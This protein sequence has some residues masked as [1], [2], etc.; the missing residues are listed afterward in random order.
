MKPLPQRLLFITALL[1]ALLAGFGLSQWLSHGHETDGHAHEQDDHSR[2]K[3]DH[4]TANAHDEDEHGQASEEEH[5]EDRIA[6]T[7]RQIERAGIRVTGIG[8]GG[9]REIRLVG[10]VEPALAARASITSGVTARVEQWQVEPGA[11][12]KAGQVLVT[13][14]SSE[15]ANLHA[16]AQA[17]DADAE[18]ARLAYRR[19]HNLFEHGVIARQ[20][21]EASQARS[22]AA[23]AAANAARANAHLAGSP[24]AQGRLQLRSPLDGRIGNL[25]A[26]PGSTVAAGSTLT[27][28]HDPQRSELHFTVTPDVVAQLGTDSRLRVT[29]PGGEFDASVLGTS[30]SVSESGNQGLLRARAE[31]GTPLALGVPLSAT[32][33]I[34]NQ[35]ELRVPSE[36]VQIVEG[37]SVVFVAEDTG[38]RLKPVLTGRQAAGHTEILKG[39]EG[40]ER[41]AANNAFLLKAELAKGEAGHDH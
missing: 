15:A 35:G 17:A 10:R 34:D 24:D 39:L 40:H 38:F 29:G 37:R 1:L 31:S 28:V 22:R 20:E 32:L 2:D 13:L 8:R 30:T 6:L 19:D 14:L 21:L 9:G 5:D 12:V 4:S 16:A 33:V 7:P 3:H 25:Q 27:E 26:M 36:A 11:S 41:I 23:D 18:A